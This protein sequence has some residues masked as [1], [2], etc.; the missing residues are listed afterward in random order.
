MTSCSLIFNIVF[1]SAQANQMKIIKYNIQLENKN[2]S[3]IC[4]LWFYF[5]SSE[6]S[7]HSEFKTQSTYMYICICTLLAATDS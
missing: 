4:V 3:R 6:I 5:D 7:L 1:V 2:V